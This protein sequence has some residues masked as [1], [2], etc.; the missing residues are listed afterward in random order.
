MSN[1]LLLHSFYSGVNDDKS[2][3]INTITYT[4]SCLYAKK[5]GFSINL[6][7]DEK[8]A[9]LLDHCPYDKIIVD[10]KKEDF[11]LA[12]ILY[13]AP[14]FKA[15]ENYPLGTIHIDG[16][17]FL[18]KK[19]LQ[20]I[21]DFSDYD[22]IVQYTEAADK[23]L[24]KCWSYAQSALKNLTFPKWASREAERMY[25]NGVLGLNN[26]TLKEEYIKTY[27]DMYNQFK[28][29]GIK[30]GVPDVIIEQQFLLNL[31]EKK[32]YTH[33]EVLTW[34]HANKMA[35]QIGYQHL[36]GHSKYHEYMKILEKIYQLDQNVYFALKKKFNH[37]IKFCWKYGTFK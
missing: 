29:K 33:K 17:V 14:K 20:E 4:L 8:G 18:K 22:C 37:I 19:G 10:L 12:D 7:T 3:F 30:Q 28:T 6:H 21:L 24:L 13:A 34:G 35:N 26:A 36:I 27:W 2:L 5:S 16:D 15:I 1:N 31:C 25:N 11:P 23:G 9:K 32:G